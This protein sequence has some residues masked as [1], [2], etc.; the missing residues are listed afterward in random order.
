MRVL[1]I[2]NR[3]A[4]ISRPVT[5][6]QSA[7]SRA[8][9]PAWYKYYAGYSEG[10]VQE[11]VERL[12]LSDTDLLID[13]WNGA[14][15]TTQ[16]A[17]QLGIRCWGGDINPA[18]VVVAKARLLRNA[19]T[20]SESSLG[21]AIIQQAIGAPHGT[22]MD[23]LSKWFVDDSADSIR[24]LE[25]QIA[26]LL[27]PDWRL[28][29]PNSPHRVSSLSPLACFFYLALF[30]AVRGFLPQF[31]STN[32]TWIKK[33]T[34]PTDRLLISS[35]EIHANFRSE[36]SKL[37]DARKQLDFLGESAVK[38]SGPDTSRLSRES[39]GADICSTVIVADSGNI[40]LA[41][42]SATAA[43]S[44]PPYCTRIDYAVAT[45]PE[46]AVLGFSDEQFK[47]LRDSMIGTTSISQ[48]P[49][50]VEFAWGPTCAE[51]LDKVSHHHSKASRTYYLKSHL[52]YFDSLARSL[53]EL[54]RVLASSSRCVLVVQD[55]YYKE[56][57]NDLQTVLAEMG[58]ALGWALTERYDFASRRHM[59][60]VNPSARKYRSSSVATESVLAFRT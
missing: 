1:F 25:R 22:L 39:E 37:T 24:R 17:D 9:S 31:F 38:Q 14:G 47:Q 32:P 30:R 23:P 57:H 35:A 8:Y 40:P 42:A 16:V 41:R 55:S 5:P 48:A 46:L 43:I 49:A 56:V 19:V 6:K 7:Q 27:D 2:T 20:P 34:S 44:S 53:R 36:L 26:Q 52:Q 58:T 4:K 15:T 60:R 10:F 33:P 21:E 13:P 59:G 18:M 28:G 50:N 45:S 54:D 29:V 12:R 3:E 51:F 11:T